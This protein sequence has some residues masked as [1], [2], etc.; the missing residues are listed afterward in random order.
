MGEEDTAFN[1]VLGPA[2][3]F[4]PTLGVKGRSHCSGVFQPP[5]L[6]AEKSSALVGIRAA[7]S[8]AEHPCPAAVGMAPP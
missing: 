1:R 7:A 4:C 5:E 6:T 2:F 3:T 8:S